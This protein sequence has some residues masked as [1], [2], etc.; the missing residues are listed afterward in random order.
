MELRSGLVTVAA[1]TTSTISN[2]IKLQPTMTSEGRTILSHCTTPANHSQD[3]T[4]AARR[5][6]KARSLN[7][8]ISPEPNLL[9]TLPLN[10]MFYILACM[11]LKDHSG[12]SCSS[13][14]SLLIANNWI[15]R[16]RPKREVELDWFVSKT[17]VEIL[18]ST[19]IGEP[20]FYIGC[21]RE[22]GDGDEEDDDL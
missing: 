14:W 1:E 16:E 12:F 15:V 4:I 8:P 21:T 7:T 11:K 5:V 10:I 2:T 22:Y 18:R 9:N 20:E 6:M 17:G 13:R 19:Y 3:Q